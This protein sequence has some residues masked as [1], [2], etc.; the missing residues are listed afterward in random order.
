MSELP[1]SACRRGTAADGAVLVSARS[2]SCHTPIVSA[3]EATLAS[4]ATA[5]LT[6]KASDHWREAGAAAPALDPVLDPLLRR[7]EGEAPSTLT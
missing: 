5:L 3:T 7:L 4:T 6:T 2:A 1:S